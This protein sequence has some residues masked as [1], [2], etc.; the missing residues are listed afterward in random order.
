MS[1]SLAI[2]RLRIAMAGRQKNENKKITF[3]LTELHLSVGIYQ[4]LDLANLI[5][6]AVNKSKRKNSEIEEREVPEK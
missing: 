4:V 6:K 5:T 2:G 3:W 1:P